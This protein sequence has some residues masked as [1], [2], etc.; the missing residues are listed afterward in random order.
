MA[1]RPMAAPLDL[2]KQF[3]NAWAALD[4]DGIMSYFAEDAVYHNIPI[5]PLVGHDAIRGLIDM[6]TAGVDR[7]DFEILHAAADGDIVY[8]E[9]VDHFYSASG[10]IDLPVMGIFEIEGDKIAKWRDYFDLNQYMS[11]LPAAE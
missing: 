5:D 4:I 7:V 8:T 10:Q 9:R 6:F 11:Q 1:E 3:C 2:V